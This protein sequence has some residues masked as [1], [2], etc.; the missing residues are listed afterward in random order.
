[1]NYINVTSRLSNDK[2]Q[3]TFGG[4]ENENG[5]VGLQYSLL[6]KPGTYKNIAVRY[7]KGAPVSPERGSLQVKIGPASVVS[8]GARWKLSGKD[9]QKSM[10]TIED[11]VPGNYTVVFESLGGWSKPSDATVEIEAGELTKYEGVYTKNS[12]PPPSETDRLGVAIEPE[13]AVLAGAEWRIDEGDWL[14]NGTVVSNIEEGEHVVSFKPIEGWQEPEDVTMKIG[15][16]N[17]FGAVTVFVPPEDSIYV[18][19]TTLLYFPQVIV[20]DVWRSEIGVVNTSDRETVSG[21]MISY[22]EKGEKI[23]ECDLVL[24]PRQRVEYKAGKC[25]LTPNGRYVVF[26]ASSE[27]VIGYNRISDKR[28]SEVIPAT[29]YSNEG[30]SLFIPHIASSSLW[31]TG[32]ALINTTDQRKENI[33]IKFDDGSIRTMALDPFATNAFMIRN[34]FEGKPMPA[35]QSAIIEN[36]E[37]LIGI[38]LFNYTG[39]NRLAAISLQAKPATELYFP[40]VFFEEMDSGIMVYNPESAA[41]TIT[42]EFYDSQGVMLGED[43]YKLPGNQR[44]VGTPKNLGFPEKTS[45]LRV[46][47]KTPL[48]G[49]GIIN[50]RSSEIMTGVSVLERPISTGVFPKLGNLELSRLVFVNVEDAW[51]KVVVSAMDDKGIELQTQGLAICP[52]CQVNETIHEF[53]EGK[54][55]SGATYLKFVSDG[56]LIGLQ[57]NMTEDD[58]YLDYIPALE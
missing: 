7:T 16:S 17:P 45:W 34:L 26:E 20:N 52:Y 42:M 2:K 1:M 39:D 49:F 55:I 35:L 3:R 41:S 43:E 33:A 19:Q 47:S 53:F 38:V 37:G 32:V 11:L 50:A 25:P 15:R 22:D 10:T 6:D 5:T 51:P 14:K 46:G 21:R 44:Y 58:I 12:I 48:L 28:M 18:P 36:A 30:K 4:I 27:A 54:D 8:A 9:W 56:P 29:P 24:K 31:G 57:M 13:E 40:L 23:S